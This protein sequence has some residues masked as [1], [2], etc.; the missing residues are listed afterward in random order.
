MRVA[1]R[2]TLNSLIS[3]LRSHSKEQGETLSKLS[4]GKRVEKAAD[5][6]ASLSLSKRLDAHILSQRQAIRNAND[7]IS[8]VQTAEGGL[9]EMSNVLTRLRE[10][11]VQSGSDT[12]GETERGFLDTEFQSLKEEVD[13]IAEVTSFNGTNVINGDGKGVLEFHV[14]ANAGSENIIKFDTD[15][16]YADTSELGIAS[17]GVADKDEALENIEAIDSALNKIA[18]KRSSLGATQSRLSHAQN[19]LETNVINHEATRSKLEDADMAHEAAKLA[20]QKLLT[21]GSAKALA[22]GINNSKEVYRLIS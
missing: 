5:D 8:F 11:S 7:G 13:R 22:E 21:S 1:A 2:S 14:G 9:S 12:V 19:N 15:E 18:E 16:N 20:S 10:L 17:A 6:A 3:N 4:S